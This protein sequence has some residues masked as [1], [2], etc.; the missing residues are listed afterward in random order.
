MSYPVLHEL[1]KKVAFLFVGGWGV[2]SRL[3]HSPSSSVHDF[4]KTVTHPVS[5]STAG[6][7]CLVKRL[8]AFPVSGLFTVLSFKWCLYHA[9]VL[10]SSRFESFYFLGRTAASLD[11]WVSNFLQSAWLLEAKA[12]GYFGTSV[13]VHLT[14][15]KRESSATPLWGIPISQATLQLKYLA[16]TWNVKPCC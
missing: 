16:V 2:V 15:R 3:I 9:N 4:L 10:K 12:P 8:V 7:F 6:C 13:T 11:E 14:S 5:S 1:R